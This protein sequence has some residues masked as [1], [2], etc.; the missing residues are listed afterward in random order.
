MLSVRLFLPSFQ[1]RLA[2]DQVV[3]TLNPTLSSFQQKTYFSLPWSVLQFYLTGRVKLFHFQHSKLLCMCQNM[4]HH[5][6][7]NKVVFSPLPRPPINRKK[8]HCSQIANFNIY[9]FFCAGYEKVSHRRQELWPEFC[10]L[11]YL[12]SSPHRKS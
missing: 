12:I 1:A 9:I 11:C 10:H 2:T 3:S 4:A 6:T 8:N 7:K 5:V